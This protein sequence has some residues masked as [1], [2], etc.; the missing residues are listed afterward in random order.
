LFL[1]SRFRTSL[2]VAALLLPASVGCQKW[3]LVMIDLKGDFAVDQIASLRASCHELQGDA[4][5]DGGYFHDNAVDANAAFEKR[6]SVGVYLPKGVRE[7]A[8]RIDAFDAHGCLILTG[9]RNFD[10]D[11]P[12]LA[13]ML[14]PTPPTDGM[15]HP[16]AEMDSGAP[17]AR[18]S[19]VAD[20]SPEVTDASTDTS[21]A[22]VSDAGQSEHGDCGADTTSVICF[23][24]SDPD[25]GAPKP[26]DGR[27]PN[28]DCETYCGDMITN[29][30][31]SFAGR[32]GCIAVCTEAGWQLPADGGSGGSVLK[33]LADNARAAAGTTPLSR[34]VAC[35]AA[36]PSLSGCSPVC[37][38]YC[39]LRQR[40]CHDPAEE[41]A[42]ET[43]CFESFSASS[44]RVTCLMQVMEH[45]VPSDTRFCQ[46]TELVSNCGKCP[47]P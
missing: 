6:P 35:A 29:C 17:D 4:A 40:F 24:P 38:P 42:C 3:S 20:L 25:A 21:N 14:F 34:V 47:R 46:W 45:D 27:A 37:I 5:I 36:D 15:C 22:E 43:A 33:C 7:F 28:S 41:A 2:F 8:V 32:D 18:D 19:A 12:N 11:T 16:L 10:V 26:L 13:L 9:S 31:G 30:P 1:I 44:A 23:D 39:L